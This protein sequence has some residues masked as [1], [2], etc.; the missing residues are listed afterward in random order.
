MDRVDRQLVRAPHQD[1][2]IP[3]RELAEMVG[4]A[5]STCSE[6]IRRLRSRGLITGFHT[7]VDL[8]SPGRSVQAPV[9]AQIRA[10]VGQ[11]RDEALATPEVVAVFVL[12]GGDDFLLHVGVGDL[13][14][15]HTS[16]PGAMRSRG[17]A[18]ARRP[19]QPVPAESGAHTCR[20]PS[21]AAWFA[22]TPATRMAKR[23]EHTGST[24][25]T[26]DGGAARGPTW[27]A[28]RS[29]PHGSLTVHPRH[30][31][32]QREWP[33][34]GEQ[35][36]DPPDPVD[37]LPHAGQDVA[38]LP[39]R[40]RRRSQEPREPERHRSSASWSTCPRRWGRGIR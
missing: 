36:G 23:L 39:R 29:A 6:H 16:S 33:V 3:V 5:A 20:T 19:G 9:F 7:D 15:S 10:L 34:S 35:A 37:Q 25:W 24:F 31:A 22:G 40:D 27:P 12:A 17:G 14:P 30:A 32:V 28:M 26:T 18:A 21:T 8:A 4:V 11:L 2:R 1:A 38:G 13:G